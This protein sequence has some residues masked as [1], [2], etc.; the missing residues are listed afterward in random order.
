M[1]P[2]G[3]FKNEPSNDPVVDAV[4]YECNLMTATSEGMHS[5]QQLDR[6]KRCVIPIVL[7]SLEHLLWPPAFDTTAST[8]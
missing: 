6:G 1:R 4:L 2:D 7:V 8:S 3:T 5:N